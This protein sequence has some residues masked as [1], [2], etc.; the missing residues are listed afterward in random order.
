LKTEDAHQG[1]ELKAL[2]PHDHV[3]LISGSTQQRPDHFLA[4][5]LATGL[6]RREKCLYIVEAHRADDARQSLQ[7]GGLHVS[8]T[9]A[10]GCLV[11]HESESYTKTLSFDPNRGIARLI[12]ETEKAR[13]EGFSALRVI[14]EMDWARPGRP[15]SEKVLEY[16]AKL[17]RDVFP[18]Y[19]CLA[20]CLYNQGNFDASTVKGALM[21]H[22]LVARGEHV[23]QNPY[24]VSADG[25]LSERR[26]QCEV[27]QLL[28]SFEAQRE[29][30]LRTLGMQEVITEMVTAVEARDPFSAGH[31]A[32]VTSL[33]CSIAE[34]MGL[35]REQVDSIREAGMLHDIGKICVPADILTKPGKLDEDEL[36]QV[37]SHSQAGFELLKRMRYPYPIPDIVLQHHERLDGSGYP[38]GLLGEDILLE[39]RILAVADVVEAMSLGRSHRDALGIAKAL[40]EISWR[41]GV[42]FDTGAVEACLKLFTQNRYKFR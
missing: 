5:Y 13:T 33:A 35:S 4:G 12:A 29:S 8:D 26:A 3:C 19:P 42:L 16:E 21:T 39:A 18:R 23:Y 25:F 28:E 9:E 30:R 1:S 40:Q 31:Q 7:N 22:P 37:R 38:Q 24:Y 15:G 10:S 2:E 6:S 14:D 17:N 20:L 27:E 11:F 41:K 34:E 36:G 32:R